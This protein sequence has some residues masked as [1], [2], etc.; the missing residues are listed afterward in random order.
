MTDTVVLDVSGGG[1]LAASDDIRRE[2][3]LVAS[4][5]H[6]PLSRVINCF[7][8]GEANIAKSVVPIVWKDKQTDD[9]IEAARELIDRV[10]YQEGKVDGAFIICFAELARIKA[11]VPS[12]CPGFISDGLCLIG[13]AVVKSGIM[14]AKPNGRRDLAERNF[15]YLAY[16][17]L[18]RAEVV[19][20]MG[21][22]LISRVAVEPQLQRHGIGRVLAEEC[23]KRAPTLVPGS[24]FIEV[25]T[26]QRLQDAKRLLKKKNAANDFLQAAGFRLVPILTKIQKPRQQNGRDRRLYYWAAAN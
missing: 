3:K 10:H 26:S 9:D 16:D 5:P 22:A 2:E 6:A 12:F 8:W 20:Q 14:Y 13:A 21:L 4:F 18:S 15:P 25:M 24:R 19:R 23:R 11:A 7:L 17:K 1:R